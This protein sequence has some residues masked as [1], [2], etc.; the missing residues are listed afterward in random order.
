MNP[1][2]LSTF[3]GWLTIVNFAILALAG[4]SMFLM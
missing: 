3:F 4:L 1:E 2:L